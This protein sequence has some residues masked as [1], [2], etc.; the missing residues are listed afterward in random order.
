MRPVG[1]PGPRRR[2]QGR[3]PSGPFR[4]RG[5][6]GK[7]RVI[8]VQPIAQIEDSRYPARDCGHEYRAA[9]PYD[10]PRFGECTYPVSAL[11]EM[12]KRAEQEHRIDRGVT[13]IQVACIAHS[14]MEALDLGGLVAELLYVKRHQITMLYPVPELG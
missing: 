13:E 3:Q 4:V 5:E 14:G 2:R 6:F 10:P 11:T 9:G 7:L 1:V 12:V 8:Q